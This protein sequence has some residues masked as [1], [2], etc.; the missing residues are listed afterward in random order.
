MVALSFVANFTPFQ[1]KPSGRTTQRR[2]FRV[3]RFVFC[4]FFVLLQAVSRIA[5]L[6]SE[7]K[8]LAAH[9]GLHEELR[10]LPL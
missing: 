4:F 2:S 1:M 8:S 3:D 9:R 5:S 10:N 7:V 6:Q